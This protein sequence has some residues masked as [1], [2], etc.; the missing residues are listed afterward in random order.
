MPPAVTILPEKPN[1]TTPAQ[2]PSEQELQA[3]HDKLASLTCIRH[4][5]CSPAQAYALP[6]TGNME[7]GFT[8]SPLV[9]RA[10][11]SRA[12]ACDD[13]LADCTCSHCRMQVRQ[14]PM[15]QHF[16]GSC[17]GACRRLLHQHRVLRASFTGFRCCCC[18]SH[19]LRS[20]FR[21]YEGR[22]TF[23]LK[24]WCCSSWESQEV[25]QLHVCSRSGAAG[26]CVAAP[27]GCACSST[28]VE[29]SVLQPELLTI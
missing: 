16:K 24:R 26:A 25:G 5:G 13:V 11:C 19:A 20:G 9:R 3:A 8:A 29:T 1:Y 4:I 21:I 2:Q 15:F 28:N 6:I 7:Y 18:Y 23:P 22:R 17:D 27:C 14:D 10:A 12:H